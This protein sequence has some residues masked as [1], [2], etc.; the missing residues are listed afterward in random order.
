MPRHGLQATCDKAMLPL[1]GSM[2]VAAEN[3]AHCSQTPWTRTG[4]EHPGS[5][6]KHARTGSTLVGAGCRLT[7]TRNDHLGPGSKW[8]VTR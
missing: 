2:L 3:A 1:T 4:N 7:V 6:G 5:W 8:T